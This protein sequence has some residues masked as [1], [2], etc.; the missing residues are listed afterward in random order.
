M[1]ESLLPGSTL[2]RYQVVEAIG[3]GGMASVFRAHDPELNRFVAIKVLPSFH[4]DDPTFVQR[5]RQEAQAVAR[6]SHPNVIQVHDFGEDKGFSYI[7][8]EL[9]TGGTLRDR[10][11][12]RMPLTEAMGLIVPL[13]AALDYAHQR[14]VIHRDIKPTNVLLDPDGRPLLSDFGLAR[15]LENSAGLT[16]P[17]TIMGTPEYMAPELALGQRADQRADLYALGIIIYQMLLGKT[18]FKSDTPSTTLMAQIHSPVPLPSAED[19]EFDPMLELALIKALAK[20]PNDRYQSS[21]DL[22]DGLRQASYQPEAD[23][24]SSTSAEEADTVVETPTGPV[25]DA[26]PLRGESESTATQ[27]TSDHAGVLAIRHA[28]ADTDF[29]GSRYSERELVWEVTSSEEGETYFQVELSYRPARQFFGK[30]GTE[31]FT[32]D[33]T[34]NVE[35]RQLLREPTEGFRQLINES[36]EIAGRRVPL[37]GVALFVVIGVIAGGLLT[38]GGLGSGGDSEA[39]AGIGGATVTVSPGAPATLTSRMRA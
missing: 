19:P 16:R 18:P 9:V 17:D 13:A 4:A 29:Y 23:T 39:L 27:I 1:V 11:G 37:V 8:M 33:R 21:S 38:S 31:K 15:L 12:R 2:G 36:V 7:V 5:F 26:G 35:L 3:R 20:D 6:L 28:R 25:A 34:G 10:M 24:G 22:V 14:G 32:I 30:P